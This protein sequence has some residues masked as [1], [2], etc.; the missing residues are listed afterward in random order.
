VVPSLAALGRAA[1]TVVW[2][3][4]VYAFGQA[5]LARSLVLS[6]A[7]DSTGTEHVWTTGPGQWFSVL[8]TCCAAAAAVLAVLTMRRVE[9]A[10]TAIVDDDTLAAA[11]AARF[12]PAVGL[13]ALIVV[14]LSLPAHSDLTG[15]G[16]GL[17]HGYDLD[18]WGIWALAI[19]GI[20][21][22]WAA[23]LTHRSGAAA[24]W[25]V[26]AAAVV[27]QSLIVPP[28]VR[29]VA[30]FGWGVGLWAV[31]AAVVALLVAAPFFARITRRVRSDTPIP[32]SATTPSRRTS[33][34]PKGS[35]RAGTTS[36]GR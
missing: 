1:A 29:A 14:G 32:L 36:K 18:T 31:L 23:A 35:A 5:L 28:A 4:A 34:P 10:S 25:L 6:T 19:G 11:R 24:A 20:I 12:W 8:G 16:P 2:A 7:G 9:Q 27:G 22:V 17:W 15:S 13:T 21:G 26:A 3:G 30:G 33:T